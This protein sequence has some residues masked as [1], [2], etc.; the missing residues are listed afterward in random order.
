MPTIRVYRL[1]ASPTSPYRAVLSGRVLLATCFCLC[2]LVSAAQCDEHLSAVADLV[3]LVLVVL[4]S[5]LPVSQAAGT[6]PSTITISG[7]T[8]YD[9]RFV[10]HHI[11]ASPLYPNRHRPISRDRPAAGSF[12]QAGE[13]DM[14]THAQKHSH[15]RMSNNEQWNRPVPKTTVRQTTAHRKRA[16]PSQQAVLPTRPP[17]AA[18]LS[19]SSTH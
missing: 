12:A 10:L 17:G 2:L 14:T 6:L 11:L 13:P 15:T 19:M 4:P 8:I 5:F 18:C 1:E 16:P 9:E 7:S 3:G